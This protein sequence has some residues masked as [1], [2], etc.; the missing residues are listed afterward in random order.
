MK[1]IIARHGQTDSNV[2]KIHSGQNSQVPLNAEGIM[3]AKKLAEYLKGETI[4]VAY[5][6]S[7]SRALDTAKE[8]LQYHP[9]VT[10]VDSPH[11]K[12]QNLGVYENTSKEEFHE[13]KEKSSQSYHA[14]KPEG[15]ESYVEVQNRAVVFF[16]NLLEKHHNETVFLVSHGGTLGM[17]YLHLLGKDITQENYKAYRPE[18]TALTVVE[19]T[20]GKPA[21][22]HVMN[23][24]AHLG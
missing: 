21:Q 14:F 22:F 10:L 20:K 6:S 1:V 9:T 19:I 7:Q 24:L 2:K 5:A 3:Q 13:I 17:L 23:S 15:G 12:E 4:H 16:N 11:L 8:V 18:N